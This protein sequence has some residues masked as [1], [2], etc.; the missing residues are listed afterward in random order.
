MNVKDWAAGLRAER[1]A[2]KKFR[3]D[4][5]EEDDAEMPPVHAVEITAPLDG[6]DSE[7]YIDGE[8]F[9][10]IL[11]VAVEFGLDKPTVV[12]LKFYADV[13]MHERSVDEPHIGD[14]PR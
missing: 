4:K 6:N 11:D 12:T 10:G 14:D 5:P 3:E 9:K 2:G 8:R 7:L 1:L 13:R